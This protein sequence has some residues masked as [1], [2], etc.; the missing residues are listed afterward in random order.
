VKH[1]GSLSPL[2]ILL[3]VILGVAICATAYIAIFPHPSE[4]FT[5]LYLLGPSGKASG[6]PTNL[7]V[8]QNATV[9]VGVINHENSEMSYRLVAKFNNTTFATKSFTLA[10]NEK[11]EQPLSFTATSRGAS[12]KV[13]FDLLKGSD[14]NVYRSVYLF[15]NVK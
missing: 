2:S 13:T 11:W 8:G 3:I 12:Q 15:V 1:I 9:V 14:A 4:P 7:S 10:N 6:Y 5:E